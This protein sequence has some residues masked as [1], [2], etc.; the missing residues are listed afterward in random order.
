MGQC[1]IH[2]EA[3]RQKLKIVDDKLRT[4]LDKRTWTINEMKE[5]RKL[6]LDV[7]KYNID[8]YACGHM[9]DKRHY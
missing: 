7:V 1:R 3:A 8:D 6:L 4:I 9:P 2:V 5:I